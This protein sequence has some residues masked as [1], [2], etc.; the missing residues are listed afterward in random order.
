MNRE[1][2]TVRVSNPSADGV[3]VRASPVPSGARSTEPS[4][5]RTKIRR[6]RIAV[7]AIF[8]AAAGI[9]TFLHVPKAL[10]ELSRTE[11]IEEVR[12]GHVRKITITDNQV[13]TGVST[14]RGP[15]RTPYKKD[16]KEL[17]AELRSLGIEIAFEDSGLGLI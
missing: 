4:R 1:G 17:I 10:P 2:R 8:A 13:I 5:G 7:A 15:F 6:A 14:T 16:E 11:F 9:F 3:N 12:S